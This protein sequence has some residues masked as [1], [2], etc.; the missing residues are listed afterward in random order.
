M[1]YVV[2]YLRYVVRYL[3]YVVR[4]LNGEQLTS[5]SDITI[6]VVETES[7]EDH[8]EMTTSTLTIRQ[9]NRNHDGQLYN[10]LAPIPD[11]VDV[12]LADQTPVNQSF[13]LSVFCE[14]NYEI[15][16]GVN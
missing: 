15:I 13:T 16:D 14:C 4:Y 5:T 11:G 7:N 10:C 3:R 2:R 12:A 1:R 8:L 6:S 9:P